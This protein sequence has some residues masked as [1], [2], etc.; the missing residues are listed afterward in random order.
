[1]PVAPTYPGV[2]IEEI[3]SGVRTIT[4]VATSITAFIG[5]AKRGPIDKAV[6]LLGFA[7]Y[8]RR[9]GGLTT[10]SE[11]GYAV[12]QFFNNG[13]PEAW[14]VRVA[15]SSNAAELALKHGATTVLKV[16]AL[17]AGS[18]GNDIRLL[19]DNNT[20]NP[21]SRF[22]LTAV[23]S[24]SSDPS[25]TITERFEN[26]SMN[27]NDARY[28]P[29]IIN[30]RS[31]LISVE[32]D[33]GATALVTTAGESKS[34]ELAATDLP[35]ATH[36]QFRI[37]ANRSEPV[38]IQLADTDTAADIQTKIQAAGAAAGSAGLA[39]MT[40]TKVSNQLVFKGGGFT[41]QD[42]ASS[43]TILPGLS[44]DAS[45]RLKL[46]ALNG[47]V[48]T[49]AAAAMNPDRV[50]NAGS[51]TGNAVTLANLPATGK[52][53]FRISVNGGVPGTVTMDAVAAPDAAALAQQLQTKIR[54]LNLASPAY[55]GFTVTTDQAGTR[56]I[57]RS[58][59]AGSGSSV[60]VSAGAADDLAGPLGLTGAGVTTTNGSDVRLSGGSEV[61]FD[62]SDPYAS[63]LASRTDRK[64]IYAL[65]AVNLF[66]ILCIPGVSNGATLSDA[67]SYC[68]ERR[69]FLVIDPPEGLSVDAMEAH[70]KSPEVPKTSYAAVYYPWLKIADPIT[71]QLKSAPPSGTIAG[72]MAR[73]DS[74]RGV[75]KA[76]AG[77]EA[78]LMGVLGAEYVLTDRQNGVLNPHGVNVNRVF[79]V[80]G[81][82]AWGARTARGDDAFADE[83]K[84]IPV[85]R[86]ALYIEESL[87]RGTQWVVFEPN[88]EPLWAQIRLNVGAFMHN[89]FRQGAFQGVTPKDAYFVKC[90][91]ETTTQNDINL[92]IVNIVV[93]FAPLK[94]AEFVIIKLH[95]M[96][97]QIET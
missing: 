69:A 47:G 20:S 92:G 49:D 72:V 3:S 29:T 11:L 8:E 36:N 84:Y 77:T 9:F 78:T 96:A 18:A 16:K 75:W 4:G 21:A 68:Q 93:G 55:S 58:G 52:T 80:Y 66:N 1:M 34:G 48:E 15:K 43:V 90:D 81:P 2:Y 62:P 46:G 74:S 87:Y 10:D 33:A 42:E 82:V 76:P 79:P 23:Y 95:Q 91:K 28:A 38:T 54:N 53:T 40:V 60:A 83:W 70:M 37:S 61:A 71:G 63:I 44:N 86:T 24:S 31:T 88:D 22:N 94:P 39:S 73:T 30:G 14:V 19:V 32:R 6:R 65:E 51:L 89:L 64:G 25:G 67:A 41:A 26:L 85:R 7:D 17:D 12:R 56:L 97:G 50:P 57:L 35:D 45:V 59:T 27:K 5:S 13:G